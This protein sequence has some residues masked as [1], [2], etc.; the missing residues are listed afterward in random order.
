MNS[1]VTDGRQSRKRLA[2][3]LSLPGWITLVAG[4]ALGEP[5]LSWVAGLFHAFLLLACLVCSPVSAVMFIKSHEEMLTTA[6]WVLWA[7][8]P[9]LFGLFF[10]LMALSGIKC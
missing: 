2:I 10:G 7:G 8:V 6:L 5:S 3:Y 9:F 1:Q 4:F